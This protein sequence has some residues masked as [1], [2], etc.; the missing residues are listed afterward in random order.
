MTFLIANLTGIA[1]GIVL[2]TLVPMPFMD[3]PIRKAWA[4]A[5]ANTLGRL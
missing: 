5:Y 3:D 1:A 4:W 2:K